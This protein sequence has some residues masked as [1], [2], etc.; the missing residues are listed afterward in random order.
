[1]GEVENENRVNSG[2]LESRKRPKQAPLNEYKRGDVYKHYLK[3]CLVEP[4]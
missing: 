3:I 4:T 2:V 1:M